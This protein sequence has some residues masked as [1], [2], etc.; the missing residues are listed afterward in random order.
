MWRV[1]FLVED[2]WI[3]PQGEEFGD[4][5]YE[6]FEEADTHAFFAAILTGPEIEATAIR[7]VSP[8]GMVS[9]HRIVTGG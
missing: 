3:V 8:D 7:I 2:K 9:A 5:E 4:F 1:E 6:D